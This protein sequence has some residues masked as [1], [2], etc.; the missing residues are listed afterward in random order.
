VKRIGREN[1]EKPAFELGFAFGKLVY[2]I[3]A[4][5]DYEKDFRGKRFNAFRAAF[6]LSEEKLTPGAKRKVAAVLRDSESEISEKINQL[7]IAE[8][9]KT[10]FV[11][12]LSENLQRKLKTNLPVLKTKSV[13][14]PKPRQTFNQRW[15]NAAAKARALARNYSWQMPLVFLFV[16]AFA[17]IAPARAG[18]A[19]SARECFDLSF[20]LMALGAV[21]GSVLAFPKPFLQK[22]PKRRKKQAEESGGDDSGESWCDWCDCDCCCDCDGC[23]DGCDCCSGCCDNCGCDGCC[24]GCDCGCDC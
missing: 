14:A 6:R 20:N 24:D 4:F 2:L 17:L 9:Q 8:N 21:F 15:Q 16:F 7:P 22:F 11:S 10:L 19:K 18:E 5:E 3:D 1:L 13:C 23:C 12:R